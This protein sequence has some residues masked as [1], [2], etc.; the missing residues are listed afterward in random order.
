MEVGGCRRR[1]KGVPC[2]ILDLDRL[3]NERPLAFM[4]AEIKGNNL[5]LQ[6]HK[7]Q[8]EKSAILALIHRSRKAIAVGTKSYHNSA[9]AK[10]K[11]R[12]SMRKSVIIIYYGAEE[13][14]KKST[15]GAVCK[16]PNQQLHDARGTY[17]Y[18][19]PARKCGVW[20]TMPIIMKIVAFTRYLSSRNRL[21]SNNIT[22][23]IINH[24]FL[25]RTNMQS[26]TS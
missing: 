6:Q 26:I 11:A 9:A 12:K 1:R 13:R 7:C 21:T 8:W 15:M 14:A 24:N 20:I 22:S 4:Q 18:N 19:V 2:C 17:A 25:P 16:S 10:E 23:R 3:F 5:L